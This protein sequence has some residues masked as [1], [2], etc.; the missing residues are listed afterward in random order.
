MDD[1]R[2]LL[3]GAGKMHEERK[4]AIA[5]QSDDYDQAVREFKFDKRSQ[6]TDRTKTEEEIA[7]EEKEKLEKLEVS[8]NTAVRSPIVANKSD[9][10][11]ALGE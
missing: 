8:F 1:I 11:R 10:L 9:R 2:A 6:P 4:A 7:L 3:L 5:R